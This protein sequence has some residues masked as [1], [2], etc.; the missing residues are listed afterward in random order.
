MLLRTP[1]R[2]QKRQRIEKW[3]EI[4]QIIYLIKDFHPE[5]I[6]NSIIRR[7]TTEIKVGVED[8][9]RYLTKEDKEMTKKHMKRCSLFIR[10]NTN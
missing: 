7:Q 2:K 6:K 1:S 3:E 8:L 5:Y 10:E 4:K 9:N